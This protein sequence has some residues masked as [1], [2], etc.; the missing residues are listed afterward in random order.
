MSLPKTS[1]VRV[2]FFGIAL[3]CFALIVFL[4]YIAGYFT[5]LLGHD[6]ISYLFEAQ[7]MLSGA[8]LY[9]PHLAETNP[10]MIIWFSALPVLLANWMHGSAIFFMRLLITAMLL[11]SAFWCV[12]ILRRGTAITSPITVALV[13]VAL[14]AIELSIGPYDFGQREHILFILLVPYVLAAAI[15]VLDR[16][17]FA[18][19]CA[20]G[21]AAGFAI[22]FKPQDAVVL[23]MLELFLVFRTRSFRRL[24]SPEFLALILTSSFILALVPIFTP[25]Y[26]RQTLPLLFDTYWAL[27]AMTTL[28]LALS[29]HHYVFIVLGLLV[30]CILLR[31]HERDPAGS[32]ALFLCSL[33]ASFAYDIQHTQWTYHR[34]PH[35]SFLLLAIAYLVA[36]LFDPLIHTLTAPPYLRWSRFAAGAI[37]AAILCAIAVHPHR[38]LSDPR[39]LKDVEVDQLFAQYKPSTTVYVFTT[40]VY[41]LASAYNHGLNW[42]S[43]FAHLWMLPAVI[44]NELG[45]TGPPAPFKRLSPQRSAELA[46]LLRGEVTDDLNYWR[47]SVVLVDRCTMEQP[48]IGLEKKN[49]NAIPWFLQSPQFAEAWSHYKRQGDVDGYDLYRLTP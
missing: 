20:L 6:Q 10:P 33:A 41:P 32:V 3:T 44:Q 2:S 7:R 15:G 42:G 4:W 40:S 12:R 11:G 8:Q 29:L 46:A 49:F 5:S 21:V 25:L 9:G 17:S 13:G 37:A 38:Y 30:V 47:P 48:C 31:R 22:W 1:S 16:L 23:V 27:G 45:P 28:A 34:Y 35:R 24:R 14:V 43:R 39:G 19:R 18:E 26:T 36:D